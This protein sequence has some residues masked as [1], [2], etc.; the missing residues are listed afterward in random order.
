MESLLKALGAIAPFISQ[1]PGW[2]R[3]C[4]ALWIIASSGMLAILILAPRSA[5]L[6]AKETARPTVPSGDRPRQDTPRGSDTEPVSKSQVQSGNNNNQAGRDITIYQPK[7]NTDGVLEVTHVGFTYEAEFDVMVRNLGDTELII[8]RIT[9]KKLEAPGEMVLPILHPTATYH[10]P[11]DDIPIG[12]TK[13]LSI[14]HAVP[15]RSADRFLIALDTTI[16]YRL[17]VILGYNKDKSA[18]FTEWCW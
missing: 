6:G 2:V 14:S 12:G 10:V 13:S 1:Y 3:S 7:P 17:R 4:F 18:E 5:L 9:I 15:A 8:H 16:V 11:V